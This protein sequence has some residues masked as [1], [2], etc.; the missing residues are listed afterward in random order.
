[1]PDF[2]WDEQKN[3]INQQKH[4]SFPQDRPGR[5]ISRITLPT[6]SKTMTTTKK[7]ASHAAINL[8]KSGRTLEDVV[9]ADL[10]SSK[11]KVMDA[12]LLAKN[13]YVVPDGSIVY[14]DDDIAYDPDFDEEEWQKPISF[15]Q[16]KGA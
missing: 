14:D 7:I 4:G 11:I 5:E 12:L 2:E 10:E 6:N 13:G 9:I 16:F 15:S 3:R 8:L 1:M